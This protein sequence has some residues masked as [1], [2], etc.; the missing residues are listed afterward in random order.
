METRS[1]LINPLTVDVRQLCRVDQA[2]VVT[3][4]IR[5]Y[6]GPAHVL[7]FGCVYDY[8][9]GCDSETPEGD[10]EVDV[11]VPTLLSDYLQSCVLI[12]LD[13]WDKQLRSRTTNIYMTFGSYS[14]FI[15]G[16]HNSS[17]AINCCFIADAPRSPGRTSS[18][19]CMVCLLHV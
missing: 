7:C 1:N 4:G 2:N 16:Y 13:K 3:L 11:M 18:Q 5:G 14:F 12:G 8:C 19:A 6:P 15:C 10:G 17:A 9:S